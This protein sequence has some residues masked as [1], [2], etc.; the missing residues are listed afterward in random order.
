V[1]RS[2]YEEYGNFNTQLKLSADYELMLRFIHKHKI[3]I[4]YLP[5]TIVK[6]RMGGVSN[7]SFFVKLKANI[8]DKIAW[9]LNGLKAGKLTILRKPFSKVGQYFRSK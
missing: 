3:R 8:E 5:E 6:M 7:V 9:R 1:K 4:T 2:C